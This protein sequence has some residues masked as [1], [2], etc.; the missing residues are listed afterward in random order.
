MELAPQPGDFALDLHTDG[1]TNQSFQKFSVDVD[2]TRVEV[3]SLHQLRRIERE[4]E[5]RYR[6]GEGEALRFRLWNQDESNRDVNTFGSHG[7][8]GDQSYGA[9]PLKKSGKIG[10]RRH[11][12]EKP[13]VELGPGMKRA[14]SA[15]KG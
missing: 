5:Q 10:V 6:N 2:G 12:E 3:S 8:L 11:G 1:A 13:T 9:E 14:T 15:L 4:S 7:T